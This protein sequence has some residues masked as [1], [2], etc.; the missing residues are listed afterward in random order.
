MLKRIVIL[1]TVLALL[2]IPCFA[3]EDFYVYDGAYYL[4]DEDETALRLRAETLSHAAGVDLLIVIADDVG[5]TTSSEYC[6]DY[7]YNCN[8]SADSLVLLLNTEKS[9]V[10]AY[11]YGDAETLYTDDVI[12]EL[13]DGLVADSSEYSYAEMLTRYLDSAAA[14]AQNAVG[15]SVAA[16][17]DD[18][19]AVIETREMPEWYPTDIS[20]FTDFHATDAPRVVD[21]ADLF[22]DSEEAEM[23]AKIEEIIAATGRDLV[24][25]TDVSS[26]GLARNIYAAD[27]YQFRGYGKGS[28]YSGSVL[29][30]CMEEGNR[31]WYT[32]VRGEAQSVLTYS[33]LDQIDER[34]EPKMKAG[35]YYDGVM[36]YLDDVQS[37]Y[38]TGKAP[39]GFPMQRLLI[40][41]AIGIVAAFISTGAMVSA[42]KTVNKAA[43]AS[44]YLVKGS[45]DLRKSH[46]IFLYRTV[47]RTKREK[48]S[49]SS[50]GG[51]FSSSGGGS[52]SGSGRS[53]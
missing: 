3:A 4:N 26:Y 50:G 53:F 11:A 46:D 42:M 48:S 49:S 22:T 19:P 40:C 43:E 30:I 1:L 17:V 25:F 37:T 36:G 13:T 18:A 38:A 5:E 31:G 2:A 12:D 33:N 27:F 39:K 24:V 6:Y 35:S 44:N 29:F 21:D 9:S 34:L 28:D 10:A 23:T 41:L 51:S 52:F 20:A 32:A 15:T 7:Y 16:A 8:C 14:I 45:F 47:T